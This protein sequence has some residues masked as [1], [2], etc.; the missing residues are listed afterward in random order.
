MIEEQFVV[1]GDVT[2][3]TDQCPV[4]HERVSAVELQRFLEE[5]LSSAGLFPNATRGSGR[6]MDTPDGFFVEVT[7][8]DASKVSLTEDIMLE[9]V[10]ALKKYGISLTHIVRALWTVSH[11]HF[12]G[13]AKN[14]SGELINLL[15]FKAELRSGEARSEVE[16]RVDPRALDRLLKR[17]GMGSNHVRHSNNGTQPRTITK[18]IE[19]LLAVDLSFG[20]SG[21]WDPVRFPRWELGETA[22]ANFRRKETR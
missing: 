4:K 17:L 15:R 1:E 2:D 21:H 8:H 20:G 11:V 18:V 14:L 5:R 13:V 3:G 9:Q 16:V 10:S 19:E 6:V 22:M 7:L 12:M